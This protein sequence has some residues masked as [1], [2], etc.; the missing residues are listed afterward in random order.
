MDRPF[1]GNSQPDKVF[2]YQRSIVV[3]LEKLSGITASPN[4]EIKKAVK[5]FPTTNR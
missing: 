1:V 5:T 3:Y 2:T 4:E